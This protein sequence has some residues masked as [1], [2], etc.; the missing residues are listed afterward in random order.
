[1]E[2]SQRIRRIRCVAFAFRII[3]LIERKKTLRQSQMQ[4]KLPKMHVH[5][6]KDVGNRQP[7]PP[8]FSFKIGFLIVT[9]LKINCDGLCVCERQAERES[10]WKIDWSKS[11]TH[12]LE[13][14]WRARDKDRRY[15]K[16]CEWG[17]LLVSMQP[18]IFIQV[19]LRCGGGV[20]AWTLTTH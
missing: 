7:K 9:D 8:G 19:F 13:F 16:R 20:R 10:Q 15:L 18:G 12:Q 6:H 11:H 1:M 4:S 14:G 2:K 17:L 5:F 3:I